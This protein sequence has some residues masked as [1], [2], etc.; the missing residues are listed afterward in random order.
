[1]LNKQ[2]KIFVTVLQLI[3]WF[4]IYYKSKIDTMEIY[5]CIEMDTLF[6]LISDSSCLM[7][8]DKELN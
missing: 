1:M 4:A 5:Y 6:T 2:K 3:L 7:H 8:Q